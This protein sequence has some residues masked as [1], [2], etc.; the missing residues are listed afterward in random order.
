MSQVVT[1]VTTA[2]HSRTLSR[3]RGAVAEPR[4]SASGYHWYALHTHSNYE[5]RVAAELNVKG[6]ESYL[7]SFCE[8]HQWKDRKKLVERPLFPGY[9]FSRMIDSSH[10]RRLHSA[11]AQRLEQKRRTK[12]VRCQ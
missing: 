11:G 12:P 5:K 4:A 6:L 3:G 1:Q 2:E 7:P 10:F 9:V 8:T